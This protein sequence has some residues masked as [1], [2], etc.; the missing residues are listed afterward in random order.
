MKRYDFAVAIGKAIN[1]RV[2]V[3]N[4]RKKNN[5]KPTIFKDVKRTR[6]NYEYLV[7]AYNKGVIKGVN[8]EKFNP[9]GNLTREQAAAII[10]RALGLEG[11]APDPGYSTSYK[12]DNKISNYARDG[13]HVITQLGIMSGSSG[14]FKPHDTLTRAQ[15]AAIIERFLQYLENDLKQNYRDDILFFEY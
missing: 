6:A 5:A 10:V 12:D 14:Y 8:A 7:A 1:L 15:A 3:G 2:E 4:T 9:E 11:K 13:V